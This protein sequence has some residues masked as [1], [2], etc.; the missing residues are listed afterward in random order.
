MSDAPVVHLVDAHVYIFRA[1]HSLPSMS[2]R[3]GR[4]VAA[5]YGFASTLCTYVAKRQPTHVALCFDHALTSFRNELEPGYK[6][7]RTEAPADLEPQFALCVE[8]GHALGFASFEKARYE[9]DDVIATLATAVTAQAARAVVVTSD[10]DLAQLVTEDGRVVLHDLAR[11]ATLD[12]DGVRAR[13]GVSPAQIPDYLGLVGDAVDNL[14]GVPGVGPKGAVAALTAFGSIDAI[15]ADPAAWRGVAVRGPARL[16]AK[17]DEHRARALRTRE[18]ATVVRGVPELEV[19]VPD[20]AYRGARSAET[21]AL[22]E[23]LGWQR[24]LQRIP[25]WR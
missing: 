21:R 22:F 7:G 9:A 13:F 10:K 3:D 5:A 1:Y 6:E 18:L 25:R 20:L 11:D 14:P 19:R 17:I 23:R 24:L 4:E 15:P 8:L 12:A 16:A 2:A